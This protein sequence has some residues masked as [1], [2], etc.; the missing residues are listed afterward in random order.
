MK[1]H[2]LE[3]TL[4]YSINIYRRGEEQLSGSFRMV[5]SKRKV[6]RRCLEPK[7]IVRRPLRCGVRQFLWTMRHMDVGREPR[8]RWQ[9]TKLRRKDWIG[10]GLLLFED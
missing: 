9:R 2:L 5:T 10:W 6:G 8:S 3:G 1:S 4:H 7:S